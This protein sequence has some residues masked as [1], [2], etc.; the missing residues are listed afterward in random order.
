VPVATPARPDPLLLDAA[1]TVVAEGVA[2]RLR[3]AWIAQHSPSGGLWS[4]A[5]HL[6]TLGQMLLSGGQRAGE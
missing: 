6:V 3:A 5:A 1:Y 4:T 2:P